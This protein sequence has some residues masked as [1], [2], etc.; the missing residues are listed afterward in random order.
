MIDLSKITYQV[1]VVDEHNIWY[2]ITD[3]ITDLGWEENENEISVRS[4]F[5]VKNSD[6]SKEKLSSLMRK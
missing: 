5:T 6:V 2:N 1:F 3:V 4:S